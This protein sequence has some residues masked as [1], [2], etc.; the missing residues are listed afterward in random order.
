MIFVRG[1][2]YNGFVASGTF[3]VCCLAVGCCFFSF[4]SLELE[5]IIITILTWK[6]HV[7]AEITL[8]YTPTPISMSMCGNFDYCWLSN[9][10]LVDLTIWCIIRFI[11]KNELKY[12][13]TLYFTS[14]TTY[15]I[16]LCNIYISLVNFKW[17]TCEVARF[18][19][20]ID[21]WH[22]NWHILLVRLFFFFK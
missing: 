7:P 12:V 3:Y 11:K 14:Y 1:N 8:M 10:N 22:F 17:V 2:N 9:H 13:H 4:H 16:N 18:I 19:C 21:K 20:S 5:A 6:L 15:A